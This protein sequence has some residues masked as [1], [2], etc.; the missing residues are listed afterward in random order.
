MLQSIQINYTHETEIELIK[1]DKGN[2]NF[3]ETNGQM[4]FLTVHAN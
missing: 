3:L 2:P 4:F 1:S